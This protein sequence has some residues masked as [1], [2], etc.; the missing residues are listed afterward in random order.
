MKRWLIPISLLVVLLVAFG[1]STKKSENPPQESNPAPQLPALSVSVCSPSDIPE[2]A[3]SQAQEAKW[4]TS[5]MNG[6]IFGFSTII[7]MYGGLAGN[8]SYSNGTWTYSYTESGATYTITAT[9]ASD[10]YNWQC[11]VSGTFGGQEV[12]DWVFLQGH[13]NQDC[14][15]GW[16]KKYEIDTTTVEISWKWNVSG[17]AK[18]GALSFYDGDIVPAN[19][20]QE[21]HWATD[22]NGVLTCW[23]EFVGETVAKQEIN[24]LAVCPPGN[25]G[26][27]YE[28]FQYEG[29]I[30]N[31]TSAV[32]KVTWTENGA[33]GQWW[34]PYEGPEDVNPDGTW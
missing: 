22:S 4:Q 17:D 28:D 25:T 14:T 10:G 2:E 15:E 19:L 1:C 29:N 23:I 11:K 27:F 21:A 7:T 5:S 26:E 9:K 18:S 12:S 33:H 8:A 13:S 24:M 20:T 30:A 6:L 3:P 34:Q 32:L 31:V 16:M